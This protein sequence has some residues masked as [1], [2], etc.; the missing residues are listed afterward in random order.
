MV[1]P[2][3]TPRGREL[4]R[5]AAKVALHPTPEW[6]DELDRA[7]LAAHP[8]IA[9]D[10]ALA[11]VVSRANRSHLIHFATA[12]LRKPGQP[13]PANLGPDPLRMARDLVRRGLDASALDVYR[14]GQNVAWQRW[15]EIAFGLTTD[16]QEL[17]ELLTL[18]FR[19]ASEFIDATLAGLAAQMQLEYD[20][21]TRDVHAEH[22][23]IV[24]LILDGAPIS[25]QSAEAKLGYPLD[26]SHTAAIIWYDDPDD[27]QNHLD[28]TARAFGRALGCPQPLIAVASAAT[29][30]VWVSDAA[31]LDTDRIHQV[32]DHAPHARIAVG[33]TARG[34]DGFRRSHRD[35]LATQRMLARLRSQQR[36]AFFADIHMI[37]VLTE[38]PDS[39]ADFITST[40]GDLESAS[41]QLLT[42]VLTYINEQCNASRAA[43]VLHTHR[44]T[45]LRRLETAQRLLPRPLDH[46]IIQVAVASAPSNGAAVRPATPWKPPSKGLLA[47]HP[48]HWGADAHGWP[49]LSGDRRLGGPAWARSGCCRAPA[50]TA[51]RPESGC[52]SSASNGRTQTG[53]IADKGER[54][55]ARRCALCSDAVPDRR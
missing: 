21:L 19:S 6:L 41:P 20:E 25:R 9:A 32:L 26:R 27:N 16:P 40:L 23:R 24:E 8:S 48:N 47:R 52:R 46:T 1:L 4:I 22:R 55:R 28:H 30:W 43:H 13:V 5:Q 35:A 33:T 42:T 50:G 11:T 39:A 17:H 10:P 34:I 7:T 2:K 14:V 36:L 37:A 12:N 45:L 54:A 15:T 44:N 18:P 31:T 51:G 29:R 38:N 3:P 49:S 53:L